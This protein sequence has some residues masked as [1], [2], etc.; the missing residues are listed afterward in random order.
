MAI[1]GLDFYGTQY[2]GEPTLLTFDVRPFE[3]ESLEYGVIELT[4][5]TASGTYDEFRLL[6]SSYGYAMNEADGVILIDAAVDFGSNVYPPSSYRDTDLQEGNFYYYA[7]WVHDT[8]LS[9]WWR[10][11]VT[12]GL[13]LRNFDYCDRFYDLLPDWYRERDRMVSAVSPQPLQRFLCVFGLATDFIRTEMETLRWVALPDRISGGLLPLLAHEFGITYEPELGMRQMRTWLH[14]AVHLYKTKGSKIGVEGAV[15][16]ITGWGAV[17]NPGKNLMLDTDSGTFNASVGQWDAITNATIARVTTAP[18][19]QEGT[20]QL[21]VTATT[22][23][24]AVVG[25]V[26]SGQDARFYGVPVPAS[27]AITASVYA[28]AGTNTPTATGVRVDL[29]WYN[30]TGALISTSSGSASAHNTP[31]A[32]SYSRHSVTATSP[33][34]A[35]SADIRVTVVAAGTGEN[36]YL[37]AAQIEVAGSA[38]TYEQPRDVRITVVAERV[39]LVPNPS[40]ETNLTGWAAGNVDTTLARVTSGG[41]FGTAMLTA[42][43][44]ASGTGPWSLVANSA[45]GTSGIPV[46]AGSNYTLSAYTR[47]AAPVTGRTARIDY[48]WY[49]S[50]GTQISY[51]T[52]PAITTDGSSWVRPWVT[53]VAPSNAAFLRVGLV[54]TP[55]TT[56]SEVHD[57]DGVLV[58]KTSELRS[59]FDASFEPLGDYM[60]ES[61]THGSRSH[62]YRRRAIKHQRLTGLLPEYLPHGATFTL[63]YAQPPS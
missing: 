61:V 1:Y 35:V 39:N 48:T 46:Q 13:A 55:V 59:Y 4:W 18:L 56:A 20:G 58:E 33:A 34:T 29:R 49:T 45:S 15:S 63:L 16:A 47:A 54:V 43:A 11:G 23:G 6:R 7:I 24:D 62:L 50:A 41:Y 57:W 40:F 32:G 3:A 25:T 38:T 44:P 52:G 42:T 9:R 19:Q 14:N 60:W 10:A 2:Y 22:A 36:T 28:L 51:N 8:T 5:R 26:G 12:T 17:V 21:R 37:D 31:S 30:S 27:T 53:V